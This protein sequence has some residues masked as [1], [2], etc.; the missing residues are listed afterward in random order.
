[1]R[2][3][4]TAVFKSLSD[5]TRRGLFERLSRAGELSVRELTRP[6]GVSQPAVSKHLGALRRAGLVVERRQGRETYY[7]VLPKGLAP[8]FNWIEHY[9]AFWQD[10]F[11]RLE[12]VLRRMDQ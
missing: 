5:P 10:R 6:S 8:V 11:V 9:G 1:M 2:A 7:R 3:E 4:P 12:D